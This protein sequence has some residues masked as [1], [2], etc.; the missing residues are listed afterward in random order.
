MEIKHVSKVVRT[1][2]I[3]LFAMILLTAGKVDAMGTLAS[4]GSDRIN[5]TI[6]TDNPPPPPGPVPQTAGPQ[7]SVAY[8]TQWS[9]YVRNYTVKDL[10]TSGAASKLTAIN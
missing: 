9:I 4:S 10:D 7:R 2:S 6:T 3:W 8:F 5:G 1:G